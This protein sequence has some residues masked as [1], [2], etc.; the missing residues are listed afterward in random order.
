[1]WDG[2]YSA[3]QAERGEAL[4]HKQCSSCHGEKLT[5]KRDED[6]P[7]LAGQRF[8]DEW[9]HR[10]VGDLFKKILR[11]MPQDDP[12]SLTSQQSADIVAFILSFNI[13]PAGDAEL[14]ADDKALSIIRIEAKPK[15]K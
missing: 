4:Y 3:K 15:Q 1:M 10:P 2:V 12:G 11:T 6:I 9:N 5:G 8:T 7:P 13:F 14:P